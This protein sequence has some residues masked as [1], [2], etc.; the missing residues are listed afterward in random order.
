MSPTDPLDD[1]D[2]FKILVATDIHLG[3]MEKDAVRGNDTFV[4][5]DEILRLALE[6]EVDFILLGGDLFHENKPSRKTLHSCL[7]LLRKYC[8]GDR[9]VQFEVISDQ[10]VNFG[11][12]KFPWVNYQDGNLNISI[13]VFSIHGN[14]DD[15]TGADALCALDVLSCAGFVNHFGR[16]MSV[17]KVDISPVLLQK[18]STKLALYGLGSIPDERLYRMFVNKKVTMLRPKEDENSWFNL[19]VIHQNRSKH[20]NTNFIPEQFLDDFIDLVIWGHEHECKIGP[21]KNEQQL[22]YVSQPGSS[23]VTSLSP[24]EAVKKHV[25]LLRIKGRKMNMQKLPLRT[26]RRFF[27]ED[28]VLANHP[29]LFNPDNPK[30]TQAIQSFCLEKVDYSGGF[31]PFN[32]LRFSQK[33]VDRVANPKDVIHFFR[34]REQKGKTGEEINFGMLITKPASEGATLRVEDLVKQY[35]QTAE[36]NV[37]LSLLTERGMG[38]AVQEFVDKEEKDA[39]EELVKYQLEKTQRFLKE[40]HIDA[41]EDKIDEEV[42]RFRE[43]RQRNTNE[44]DDEVREAMSRARALRSQSETSTS[45]FSA[46]DLSFD[47]SEQT[48]ND[49]DD[50]LS[51][52]PSRGRGRGRGRRGARGQSS[53]P[54]GGSQR[55]R[56]TGLE[57]TTRGRSSKA[58]SST[59]RN[60]SI[61]DAFRSTRQQPSRNVAPKN[62]SETI[63]VDDSD[64][65]DIFPTNSRAD[66]RWSGTTSSKRMSQSQ[67][68]KGVDF[69]SDE[70]DDDDPF[71]SSSCP[72]RNRR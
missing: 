49:S 14:H 15:P 40:R 69:E 17:E 5:F 70:D 59:S 27:I 10:S 46:E 55:G 12:S 54:R 38:E 1:E 4:T 26:V 29:N 28:V 63:E 35:F 16:S 67:T 42:R 32:V 11:F 50:S 47:T 68:A 52:V 33:F 19:F 51:A 20:G 21:I 58:T 24:G 7:E 31:E 66:Q 3:F 9:P 8:M 30:V 65:D 13:P 62:Y 18:G 61:I 41:L 37:Q 57:I 45:A 2:T 22:F 71:M 60:M 23:V 48:A 64:E 56:D 44:E 34:H 25:G 53:A 39:I 72:R 36:K 43:S 6:N